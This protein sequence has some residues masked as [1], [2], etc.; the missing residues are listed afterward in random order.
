MEIRNC[1]PEETPGER[2]ILELA[3]DAGTVLLEN[4]AEIFRVE[5]TM[6]RICRHY[7]VE[8]PELFVL[9]NGVF[10][11]GG[12]TTRVKHVPVR[13]TRLDK[14]AAVNQ[15]SRD[16]EKGRYT[17]H[18][19]RQRLEEIREMP[20]KPAWLKILACALAAG[21]FCCMMGGNWLDCLAA[22]CVGVLLQALILWV[23]APHLSRMIGNILC[24]GWVTFWC[25][26]ICALLPGRNL[27]PMIIGT[28][29]PL[30]PGIAFTNGI[31]DLADGDS[32]SGAVRL[33]DA[34]LVF[35][36]VAIGVGVVFILYHKV[37][38]GAML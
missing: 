7:G 8:S 17:I 14:V 6:A 34:M 22:G 21:C 1:L 11:T 10:A 3:M 36:C 24:G 16:I 29:L 25:L 31:R 18:Q 12:G 35:V 9:T 23:C 13:S 27:S 2:E 20:G 38:G 5:E 33:L 4:D 28:I 26:V 15:L 32:I 30:V 19:A 37:F